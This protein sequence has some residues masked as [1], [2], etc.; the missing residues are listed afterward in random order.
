MPFIGQVPPTFTFEHRR[1][2]QCASWETLS[3]NSEG[4]LTVLRQGIT[5]NKRQTWLE[6]LG[7]DII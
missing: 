3:M 7:L 1:L 4:S 5:S 2:S 6:N